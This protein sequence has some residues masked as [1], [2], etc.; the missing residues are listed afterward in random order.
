MKK[1]ALIV[2][3]LVVIVGVALFI[4]GKSDTPSV[5]DNR[6]QQSAPSVSD[7]TSRGGSVPPPMPPAVPNQVPDGAVAVGQD[8][9]DEELEEDIKPAT[10]IYKSAD[11]ALKAIKDGAV[12]YDDIVLEQF[13]QPDEN[14]AWCP[15]FYKWVKEMMESSETKADQRSYY[16]EVL[17]ISGRVDNIRGLVDAVKNAP[18]SDSAELYA[19]A[20]ELTLGGDDVVHYLGSEFNTSN[21]TLKE[22]LVAAVTNQ[23]SRA[24]VDLLY[25]NTIEKGD[26]DGYYSIGIGLGELV[27][28]TE[29]MPYLQE[30]VQKRDQ[31]S[32]LGLKSLLNAGFDGLKTVY[33]V[34]ANS[35]NPDFD[36][37]MLK[38]AI[39]HVG[40]DEE[41]ENFLK[42]TMNES[43]S[44]VW[45]EFAKSA[46]DEMALEGDTEE[47]EG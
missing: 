14:C 43:K 7:A 45:K 31:Y 44:E 10:E 47:E 9:E 33:E 18:N 39:E 24:A 2:I 4:F 11:E 20:L 22:A 30:I 36:R 5:A 15:T 40:F 12:D 41:T 6:E 23:G 21:E 38:G 28:E 37:D 19:E 29:A 3:V 35:N 34:V 26:P 13:T 25:K 46:L 1:S 42:Q 17:A 32:H 27:P 8:D 16:A